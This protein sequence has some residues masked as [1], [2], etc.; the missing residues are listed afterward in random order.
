MG[1]LVV[2]VGVMDGLIP[3]IGRLS[4]VRFVSHVVRNLEAVVFVR[5]RC[6]GWLIVVVPRLFSFQSGEVSVGGTFS[7][8]QRIVDKRPV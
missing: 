3:R 8:D 6:F 5:S 2:F 1:L 4:I 7:S